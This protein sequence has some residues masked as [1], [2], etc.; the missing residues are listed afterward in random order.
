[1]QKLPMTTQEKRRLLWIASFIFI[2]FSFLI[3]QFYHIQILEGNKWASQP[4]PTNDRIYTSLCCIQYLLN[5]IAPSH[6]F[7][8]RLKTLID[9][10]PDIPTAD[11]GFPQNW[12]QDTLWQ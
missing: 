5:I 1:M 4:F 2:L 8:I 10:Y 9:D 7:H 12:N 3:A 11:M 6:S